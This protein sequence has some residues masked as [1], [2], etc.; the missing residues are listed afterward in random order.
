MYIKDFETIDKDRD[1]GKF[2]VDTSLCLFSCSTDILSMEGITYKEFEKWIKMKAKQEGGEVWSCFLPHPDIIKTAHAQA[3]KV[4]HNN[5]IRT[6]RIVNIIDFRDLLIH[7]FVIS[8]LWIHFKNADSWVEGYDFGNLSLTLDEFR[9][10][11]KSLSAA[12]AHEEI[13]D[14]Q[15]EKDFKLLDSNYSNSLDFLEVRS[16]PCQL[17]TSLLTIVAF[18]RCALIAASLSKCGT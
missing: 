11:C 16:D 7:L 10:A 18:Y 17:L 15:I 14:D 12:N 8:I 6:Q 9:V 2:S 5:P 3:A 13:S 4:V 1:G